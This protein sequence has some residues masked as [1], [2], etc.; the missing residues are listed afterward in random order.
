MEKLTMDL[1]SETQLHH[2]ASLIID[3]A[4]PK[5]TDMTT[6][7]LCQIIKTKVDEILEGRN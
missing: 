5:D 6:E 7:K 1:G 4:F 3:R 2:L